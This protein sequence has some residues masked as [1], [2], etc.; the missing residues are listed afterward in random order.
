MYEPPN[1]DRTPVYKIIILRCG[2]CAETLGLGGYL[3]KTGRFRFQGYGNSQ[4]GTLA[5]NCHQVPL[6]AMNRS[7]LLAKFSCFLFV[8]II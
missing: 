7:T 3:F 8:P 6:S 2:S 5:E 4:S 1:Q